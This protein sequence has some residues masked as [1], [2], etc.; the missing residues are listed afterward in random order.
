MQLANNGKSIPIQAWK[1]PE[2][3]RSLER[4]DFK[5]ISTAGWYGP[6]C[7]INFPPGVIPATHLC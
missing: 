5:T 7:F 2:G 6:T 4:P 3:S 1:G